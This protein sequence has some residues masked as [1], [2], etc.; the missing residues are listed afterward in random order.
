[1]KH[2]IFRDMG[3]CYKP[4]LVLFAIFVRRD[5]NLWFHSQPLRKTAIAYNISIRI[6]KEPKHQ[7]ENPL[8][9]SAT[10]SLMYVLYGIM[11][12]CMFKTIRGQAKRK[13]IS[14]VRILRCIH[15]HHSDYS[16]F[17]S[18]FSFLINCRR[19]SQ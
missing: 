12:C 16:P 17:F 10:I 9:L 19:K 11:A 8:H 7:N 3:I 2:N 4:T 1:M 6:G 14:L 18:V 13:K 15:K 5:A